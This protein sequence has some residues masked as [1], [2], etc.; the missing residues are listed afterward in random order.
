MLHGLYNAVADPNAGPLVDLEFLN[1]GYAD[2]NPDAA[3]LKL[4]SAKDESHRLSIQLYHRV[5]TA[6]GVDLAGREVLEVGCGRGGGASYVRR[7]LAPKRLVGVD[8]SENNIALCNARYPMDGLSFVTGDAERLD[9][10]DASFDAVLNVES[11]QCYTS[12]A[13]FFAE[14]HRVLRPGGYFLFAGIMTDQNRLAD[15]RKDF[16]QS[17]MSILH[18]ED[19]TP[20]VI[21]SREL[22]ADA[23]RET[24]KTVPEPNRAVLLN[25]GAV[26]GTDNFERLKRREMTYLLVV[27]RA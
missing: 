20:N 22:A 3:V 21:R 23:E 7:Y 1:W 24:F 15:F 26:P 5:A 17:R 9:F 2:L 19:I 4:N 14:V 18:E 13:R 11:A 8:F 27:A 6:G 10:P 16:K 12:P 25:W